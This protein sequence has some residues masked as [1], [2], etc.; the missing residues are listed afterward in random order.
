MYVYKRVYL[1]ILKL[2]WNNLCVNV[3]HTINYFSFF[4]TVLIIKNNYISCCLDY[5]YYITLHLF[6]IVFA[7]DYVFQ[8]HLMFV[9]FEKLDLSLKHS[10]LLAAILQRVEQFFIFTLSFL[11]FCLYLFVF[12]NNKTYVFIFTQFRTVKFIFYLYQLR[13][14]NDILWII[15]RCLVGYVFPLQMLTRTLLAMAYHSL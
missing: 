5:M 8:I 13:K 2:H 10:V 9:D 11:K 14:V 1:R 4:K 12:I 15:G 7:V 3:V 6:L